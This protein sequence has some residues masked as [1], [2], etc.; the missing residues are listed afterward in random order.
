MDANT[1]SA[2]MKIGK[3]E[4]IAAV[5]TLDGIPNPNQIT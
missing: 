3:N 5:A 1:A 4:M 2:L